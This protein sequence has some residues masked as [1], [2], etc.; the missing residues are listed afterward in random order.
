MGERGGDC[1]WE[2]GEY[3]REHAVDY[4]DPIVSRVQGL[5]F[6]DHGFRKQGAPT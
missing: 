1:M 2:K 4:G 3:I 6:V 5:G